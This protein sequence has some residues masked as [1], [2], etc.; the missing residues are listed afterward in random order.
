M[1][2]RQGLYTEI[3]QGQMVT[4]FNDWCFDASRKAG[5]TGIVYNDGSY[6]GYHVMYFVG[7]DIPAWQVSVK[8]A[9]ISSDYAAWLDSLVTAADAQL[10]DGMESV[11]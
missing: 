6:I 9:L 1:Y 2:K 10:L 3:L 11:G 4:E 7:E 8:N 5:D